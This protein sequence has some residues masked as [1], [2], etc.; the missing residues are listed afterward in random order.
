MNVLLPVF[1]LPPVSWFAEFL[2]PDREI[3]LEQFENFPKQTFR[4]RTLIYGANG[5]LALMIPIKH[6]GSRL[7][8][9]TE[10]SYAEDWPKQHWK[11]IKTAY[12]SSPYFEYYEDKLQTI[13][14][15]KKKYLFDFNLKV[16]DV[17]QSLLKTEV[18]FELT[19]EYI[20]EPMMLNLRD[21][22]SAKNFQNKGYPEYYQSFTA[23][24]GFIEDL[25]ILDLLCNIGPE[26]STYLKNITTQQ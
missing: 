10:I 6:N 7:Y 3:L 14:G 24:H 13:Y 25:S 16:L 26:S 1:Y 18:N 8:K 23:K 9:E 11:S 5:K 12:Q 17:I 2:K 15:E 20:K 21:K 4:N 19:R 22:F